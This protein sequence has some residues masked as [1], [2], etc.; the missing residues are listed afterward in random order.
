MHNLLAGHYVIACGESCELGAL[1][2]A[3]KER[4]E[5]RIIGVVGPQVMSKA[6]ANAEHAAAILGE[7]LAR[8][9]TD[10]ERRSRVDQVVSLYLSATS[11]LGRH[12]ADRIT[13]HLRKQ[14]EVL[15]SDP[16]RLAPAAIAL[17]ELTGDLGHH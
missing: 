9:A 15:A 6:R 1:E 12:E 10:K 8:S 11:V 4:I 16:H 13:Q 3:D 2:P 5:A 14:L 7:L 17:Q